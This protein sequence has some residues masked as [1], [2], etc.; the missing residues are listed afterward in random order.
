[1]GCV[2]VW[3][4]DAV[5]L[6]PPPRPC[7]SVGWGGGCC[8]P[9]LHPFCRPNN[10]TDSPFQPTHPNAPN[11]SI[12]PVPHGRQ[13]EQPGLHRRLP[14]LPLP[15]GPEHPRRP[16]RGHVEPPLG[17]RRA[18]HVRA[19][20]R[21]PTP[22]FTC[23][24]VGVWMY[25]ATTRRHTYLY[26]NSQSLTTHGRSRHE[27]LTPILLTP[28]PGDDPQLGKGR[29]Y[30]NF[31][32]WVRRGCFGTAVFVVFFGGG[33]MG[34]GV[35]FGGVFSGWW[36]MG[37]GVFVF[38]HRSHQHHHQQQQPNDRTHKQPYK[39]VTSN[40]GRARSWRRSL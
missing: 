13:V 30:T 7:G 29:G 31:Y 8:L 36:C 38:P 4:G 2:C 9:F 34:W 14:H 35:C 17:G 33:C 12:Q 21:F 39:H 27:K 18:H 19:S 22:P 24:C 1:M 5:P 28:D 25:I 20:S 37:W 32:R 3:R 11:P 15:Q 10:V 6:Q 16:R 23:G 26:V 40:P